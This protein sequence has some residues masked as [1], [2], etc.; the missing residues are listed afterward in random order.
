MFSSPLLDSPIDGL[1]V[2]VLLYITCTMKDDFSLAQVVSSISRI[3]LYEVWEMQGTFLHGKLVVIQYP[4][5]KPGTRE[6]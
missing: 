6:T 4:I 5:S 3:L 2:E 1:D